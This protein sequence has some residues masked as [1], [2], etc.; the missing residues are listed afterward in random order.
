MYSNPIEIDFTFCYAGC[1][2]N[3]YQLICQSD[4]ADAFSNQPESTQ[5]SPYWAQN[6]LNKEYGLEFYGYHI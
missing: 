4:A 6:E 3:L 2:I 5:H 1:E